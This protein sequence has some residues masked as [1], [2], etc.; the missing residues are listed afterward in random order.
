MFSSN[1]GSRPVCGGLE[2]NALDPAQSG[3][4]WTISSSAVGGSFR[5][6]VG[7][8]KFRFRPQVS[9]P[10]QP[11]SVETPFGFP[12]RLIALLLGACVLSTWSMVSTAWA[13]ASSPDA[14][15]PGWTATK[16]HR[17]MLAQLGIRSLRPGRSPR[18][19]APNSA[20]Y[21]ES[22]ANPFPDYPE[23]LRLRDGRAVTTAA[24]WWQ[25][26]RPEDP[27]GFRARGLRPGPSPCSSGAVDVGPDDER[28][29]RAI[30]RRGSRAPRSRGQSC[31][32]RVCGG[33]SDGARHPSV[34]T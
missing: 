33:D 25:L 20:N 4:I 10:E 24:M 7:P 6:D 3:I 13:Q 5:K 9:L 22:K 29:G 34:D 11:W 2:V 30:P 21:D 12:H 15:P 32:S 17:R 8:P 23:L 18:P 26:R 1:Q 27:G 31:V 14:A 19:G 16:D 28:P